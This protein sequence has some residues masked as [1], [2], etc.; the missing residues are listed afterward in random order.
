MPKSHVEKLSY[1]IRSARSGIVQALLFSSV[2]IPP[3]PLN[4]QNPPS[5]ITVKRCWSYAVSTLADQRISSDGS[6][7]FLPEDA[8][9]V[10]AISITDGSRLW[11]SDLG[12]EIVSNIVE[13]GVSV[14]V[15]TAP[16]TRPEI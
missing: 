14:F 15:T 6:R 12:G 11:Y 8:A 9:R 13:N 1:A 3:L 4:A 5:P 7:V 2:L 16:R 10:E